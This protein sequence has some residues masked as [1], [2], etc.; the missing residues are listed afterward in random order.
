MIRAPKFENV[1]GFD[2]AR[3]V[4]EIDTNVTAE[5]LVSANFDAMESQ[6]WYH[7]HEVEANVDCNKEPRVRLVP[8]LGDRG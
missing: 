4:F 8:E 6:N 2:T 1:E 3:N 7:D 5:G